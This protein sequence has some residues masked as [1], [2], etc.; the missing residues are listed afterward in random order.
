MP[1]DVEEIVE[2]LNDRLRRKGEAVMTYSWP[3]FYKLCDMERFKEPR[4]ERIVE[5]ARDQYGLMVAYGRNVVLVA[6]DRN[7]AP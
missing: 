1:L 5:R 6:H 2:E 3:D 4:G 7:F